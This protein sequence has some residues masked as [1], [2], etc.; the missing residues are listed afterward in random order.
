AALDG[1]QTSFL[2]SLAE[3]GF[4]SYEGLIIQAARLVAS[5]VSPY[6]RQHVMV[7]E[8]QDINFVQYAFLKALSAGALSVMIIGDPNQAIYGFRG[9]S[10]ASFEDFIRDNP[11]CKKIHLGT[12]YRLTGPITEA[13]NV[14]IGSEAVKNAGDG[15]PISIVRT[16]RPYDFLT[17]EIEALS[18]GL[19]HL[20]VGKSQGEYALSDMAVIVRTQGQA[21][22]VID[23]LARASIP[24]DA[25]YARPFAELAGVRE[26]I[27]LL[28][29]T[30]WERSVVGV[31]D[32]A[33]ERISYGLDLPDGVQEKI[34]RA[35]E[36][37]GKLKGNIIERITVLE[38]SGLFKLAELG[39]NHAFYQYA[40]LS[41]DD[42][43]GF[44]ELLRLNNDQG[45]LGAEKVHV[46][47][48][49]AAKGLEFR[50]VFLSG[51]VQ[52]VFP[53][54]GSSFMEEQNLFYVAMT[55]AM[56]KLYFICPNNAESEF[57]E[58]IPTR[59]TTETTYAPKKP[60]PGQMSLFD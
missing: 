4:Y 38:S 35:R 18:G 54:S 56:D 5:G 49:H 2:E 24:H 55:R 41:G 11:V 43:Q 52:G 1:E 29:G 27:A 7:D 16:D 37:L 46:I 40:H 59:C 36:A 48:A 60:K 3:K 34:N 50:C 51:L 31:G 12:T 53:L 33:L 44:I 22:Q 15:P 45:A 13:S 28:E 25:A 23:A 10:E 32:R 14:F 30:G 39:E 26:R 47:T 58:R 57:L 21:S 20:S 8:F 19:T 42:V 17:R 9:S 6:R